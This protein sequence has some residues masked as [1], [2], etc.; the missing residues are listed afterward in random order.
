MTPSRAIALG[1][2]TVGSLDALDAALFFEPRGVPLDRIFRG[3]A[4]GL[5]GREAAMAGGTAMLLL[6]IVLHFTVATGIVTVL[7]LAARRRP[8]LVRRPL[9]VG[10]IYGMLAWLVMNF[11][12]IPLSAIGPRIPPT[13]AVINGLLIHMAGVGIPAALFARAAS[14]ARRGASV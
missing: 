6:G 14:G 5:L 3:I 7:V 12:V 9:V 10:P 2:L 8:A 1:G 4:G 13:P 11:V